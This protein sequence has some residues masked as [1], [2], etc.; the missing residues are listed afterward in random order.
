MD[1]SARA[2]NTGYA[3]V[4]GTDKLRQ[5]VAQRIKKKTGVPTTAANILITPG[6]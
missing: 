6:G 1:K 3:S 5:T 2:G 4:P